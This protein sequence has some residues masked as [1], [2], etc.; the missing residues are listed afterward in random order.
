MIIRELTQ[1]EA[2]E[3]IYPLI[4][5]AFSDTFTY[6]VFD[7]RTEHEL[8]AFPRLKDSF[9]KREFIFLGAFNESD[10]LMGYSISFQMRSLELYTQTSVVLP[11]H[12]RKG[13]YTELTKNILR[14]AGEKGY[15]MVTSNHVASNNSVI[16]AKLKLGFYI[17][18]FEL[19]DD[20]GALVKMTYFLNEKRTRMFNVRTALRRPDQDLRELLKL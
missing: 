14:L 20:F 17:S 1:E 6:S 8:Q 2:D 16:M 10:E 15:Q 7:V 18:G 9:R 19:V 11:E 12:R 3:K 5:G 4:T 13:I